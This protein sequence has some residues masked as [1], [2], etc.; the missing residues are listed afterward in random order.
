[1]NI[2]HL[3]IAIKENNLQK[4]EEILKTGLDPNKSSQNCISSMFY[5]AGSCS[6]DILNLMT[7]YGGKIDILDDQGKG[8]IHYIHDKKMTNKLPSMKKRSEMFQYLMENGAPA[9]YD[10]KIVDAVFIP[11]INNDIESI[12]Y[13]IKNGLDKYGDRVKQYDNIMT[14]LIR[15][16]IENVNIIDFFTKLEIKQNPDFINQNSKNSYYFDTLNSKNILACERFVKNKIDIDVYDDQGYSF[17]QLSSFYESNLDNLFKMNDQNQLELTSKNIEQIAEG[18]INK[19]TAHNEFNIIITLLKKGLDPNYQSPKNKMSLIGR[20]L[21]DNDITDSDDSCAM[22]VNQLLSLGAAIDLVDD[23]GNNYLH[24]LAEREYAHGHNKPIQKLFN[25]LIDL[26]VNPHAKNNEGKTP[27]TILAAKHHCYEDENTLNAIRKNKKVNFNLLDGTGMAPLHVTT[28]YCGYFTL[29]TLLSIPNI[30]VNI[31]DK[32]GKTPL[33]WAAGS[34]D[35]GMVED[36]LKAGGDIT[37]IDNEG[38]DVYD[39]VSQLDKDKKRRVL[40]DELHHNNNPN[41]DYWRFGN[42]FDEIIKIIDKYQSKTIS[43][44]NDQSYKSGR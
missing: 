27:L 4:I 18:L 14:S 41:Y 30:N 17:C 19:S 43:K 33:M 39:H 8:L 1:M 31:K 26:G 38:N 16:K 3:R 9:K 23:K 32:D 7:K 25:N 35:K 28:Y 11:V 40:V 13:M 36:I 15:S 2:H 12:K 22:A 6:F 44:N 24:I 21:S 10:P 34:G 20:I 5:A 37:L 29:K 42:H